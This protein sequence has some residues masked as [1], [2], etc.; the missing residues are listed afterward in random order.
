MGSSSIFIYG[1]A[2]RSQLSGKEQNLGK[3]IA[4][5]MSAVL[6]VL[7]YSHFCLSIAYN[8]YTLQFLALQSW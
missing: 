6:L 4:V 7:L 1:R 3:L 2:T 8:A 5:L